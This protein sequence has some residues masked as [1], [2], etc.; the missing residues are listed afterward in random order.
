M[1]ELHLFAGAG[2][3]IAGGI[4]LGHTCVCAVEIEPYRRKVLLQRQRD[5]ILPGFPIWD[6]VRTF[7]GKPWKGKVDV[8]CGGFPCKGISPARSNNHVN[9]RLVGIDGAGSELWAHIPRIAIEC[10]YPD[11]FIENSKHLLTR[12]L[13]TI[14]TTLDALGYECKWCVLGAGHFGA[15]HERERLW[16]KATH[17]HRAQQQRGSLS[18]R[19]HPEHQNTRGSD[20][21]KDQPGL[22]R[23]E[24]GMACRLDRLKAIGAGQVPGVA[25]FAWRTLNNS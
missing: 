6:D 20:W 11:L 17:S 23:V 19:V 24:N 25:A 9:G 16:I 2:G 5:G 3:G 15:D 22:E 10:G 4:L 12:G 14:I 1:R 13:D 7:D 18:C 21:W 8:I